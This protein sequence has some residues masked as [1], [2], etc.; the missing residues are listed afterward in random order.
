MSSKYLP[1][2]DMD[3][4][5]VQI[6][7][8]SIVDVNICGDA[9]QKDKERDDQHGNVVLFHEEESGERDTDVV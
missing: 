4:I 8:A 2:G 1:V 5:I 3:A 6:N 7:G 9:D